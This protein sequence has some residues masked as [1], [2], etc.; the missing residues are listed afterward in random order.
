[1]IPKVKMHFQSAD[2][3]LFAALSKMKKHERELAPRVTDDYF[4]DLCEAIINQQLSDKAG[5]TI[6]SRF[7]ALFPKGIISPQQVLALSDEAIRGIGA[8]W[9]KV[10]FIKNLAGSVIHKQLSLASLKDVSDEVV[11]RTL[12]GVKGIG[13][14]TAEMFLM[15]SLGREDVFSYGDLGLRR[16]IQKLYGFRKEPTMRQMKRIVTKWS[17]YRTYACRILWKSLEL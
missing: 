12:T 1:M 10:R 2:P 7:Q 15:F 17:P 4:A 9:S 13:P 14:W 6:F 8:S 5:R 3:V 16:A 11:I